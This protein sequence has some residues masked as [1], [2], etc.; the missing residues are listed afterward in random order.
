MTPLLTILAT[1][2]AALLGAWAG[3]QVAL[4]RFKKE[5]AF[6][7]RT[8][9][10]ADLVKLLFNAS[11]HL[12]TLIQTLDKGH[13]RARVDA[14]QAVIA[15]LVKELRETTDLAYIY[16]DSTTVAAL[17]E[18]EHAHPNYVGGDQF[19]R[20]DFAEVCR[21]QRDIYISAAATIAKEAR[22]HLGLEPISDK[23]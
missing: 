3:A 21:K 2:L 1:T 4:Q 9:W 14:A 12:D 16:G 13:D 7:A 6:D 23:R 20:A 11:A 17:T 10:Y 22:R 5:R 19:S 8:K 15:P 18:A